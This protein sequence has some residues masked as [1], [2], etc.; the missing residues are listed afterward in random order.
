MKTITFV[1]TAF[2]MSCVLTGCASNSARKSSQSKAGLPPLPAGVAEL[3]FGDFFV[4]PIGPQGLEPTEKL[5]GLDGKRVRILGYMVRQENGLPGRFLFAAL[6]V[7]V[8]EH[9]AELA[10]DLPPSTVYVTVPAWRDHAVPH[11]PGL[12]LLTGT[13]SVG[14]RAEADGRASV[15]RL[16]LDPPARSAS[17]TITL[18]GKA[19]GLTRLEPAVAH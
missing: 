9:D 3:K 17:R 12:M 6:P 16:A 14:Q 10:D 19:S 4:T 5:L 7:Q 2:V 8:H 15:V 11:A 13:L 18:S 1:L